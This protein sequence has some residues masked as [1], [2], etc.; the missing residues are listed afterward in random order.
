[1]RLHVI[2]HVPY[3]GPARIATWA[4]DRGHEL[5]RTRMFAGEEL[6]EPD[7]S[8]WLVVLGGP[9]GV[10]DTTAYPWL[11][12]EKAFLDRVL[13]TDTTVIGVCLGAQLI[14]DVL[15]AAVTENEYREVGWYPIE[16]TLAAMESP[17]FGQLPASFPVFHWHGDTFAVPD[18]AE[19]LYTS[20]ACRNQAF[21]YDEHVF[22]LQFHLEATEESITDL[23]EASTLGD[24]PYVQ[25]ADTQRSKF[26]LLEDLEDRC[27]AVL[28]AIEREYHTTA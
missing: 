4:A 21:V 15:G 11:A 28:D 22:G 6:P 13:S 23:I 9:M 20:D 25:S 3:E 18:G 17:V 5:T 2:Q 7:A 1:M 14:A 8:D 26:D 16:E 27:Y 10:H 19:L 12:D 24:G